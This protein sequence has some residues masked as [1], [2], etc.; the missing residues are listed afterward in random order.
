M[1][2]TGPPTILFEVFWTQQK[3]KRLIEAALEGLGLPQEDY[4]FYVLI[5]AEGPWTPT[6]LSRRLEMPLSTMLFRLGRLERRGH[7][8]RVPNPD[9]RR[10]YLIRLT[11]E[12]ER[13][14]GDARP[15]FR[16][17]ALAVEARFGAGRVEELRAALE[18][19]R[20][21]VSA[22]LES[23]DPRPETPRG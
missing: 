15:A 17:Y 14:L 1:T 13:L 4:P 18:E 3:R 2:E 11:D 16:D 20:D 7:A 9:D 23:R 19:L 12:G 8:E 6:G 10:S 5:G 22:E 21:A